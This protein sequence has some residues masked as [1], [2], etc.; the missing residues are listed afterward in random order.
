MTDSTLTVD[1]KALAAVLA[2]R[3]PTTCVV[4]R[5]FYDFAQRAD[6]D[7]VK[8]IYTVMAGHEGRYSNNR[9]REAAYGT[10]NIAILGQIKLDEDSLPSACE[11]AEGTMI[12]E[13]KALCRNRTT[14][15]D[16]LLLVSC[17]Q[18]RQIEHPYAWV[19]FELTMQSHD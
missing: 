16:S 17:K 13:I 1:M 11:D 9:G 3:H 7:L 10:R 14:D 6:A 18:S 12:D 5:D 2:A 4:T 15:I 19:A 8:G